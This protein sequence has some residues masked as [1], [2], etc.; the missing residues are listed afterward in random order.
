MLRVLTGEVLDISENYIVLDVNGLGFEILCSQSALNLCELNKR[1]RLVVYLQISEAGASLFGF[2]SER[3]R[4]IFLKIISIKG[5]GGKSAMAVLSTLNI[6]EILNAVASSDALAF[7]RVPGIGRKTAERLCFELKNILKDDLIINI[8]TEDVNNN[9]A[10]AVS[11]V[12]DALISL[13]FSQADI[14]GAFKLLRAA[15]G[16]EFNNLSEEDLLRLALKEL[17]KF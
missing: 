3:E 15:R 7:T 8:N 2:E 5:I 13:G 4:K 14:A 9:K 11:T 17:N 10:G 12:S 16:D 6:N 1:V